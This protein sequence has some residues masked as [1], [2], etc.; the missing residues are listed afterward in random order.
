MKKYLLFAAVALIATSVSAQSLGEKRNALPAKSSV[1]RPVQKVKKMDADIAAKPQTKGLARLSNGLDKKFPMSSL[2]NIKVYESPAMKKM[3]KVGEIQTYYNASGTSRQL[4][5]TEWT[6]LSIEDEGVRFFADVIPNLWGTSGINY[7]LTEANVSGSTV[8]IPAQ[9]VLQGTQ[10]DGTPLYIHIFSGISANGS[11]VMTLGDDGSLTLQNGETIYYGAFSTETFDPTLNTYLG[12]YDYVTNI[13]YLFPGQIAAP[14]AEIEPAGVFLHLGSSR[15][16]YHY[17]NNLAIIPSNAAVP[18][19]NLTSGKVTKYDWSVNKFGYNDAADAMEVESVITGSEKDFSF[20]TETAGVYGPVSLTAWNEDTNSSY[21]W[22][23]YH[24]DDAN[25]AFYAYA[26]GLS[27]NYAFQDG[28]SPI[29]TTANPDNSM[30]YYATYFGTPDLM[31]KSIQSLVMY[32]GKPTAPL[33]T[34]GVNLYVR[35]FTAQPGFSLTCQIVQVSRDASNGRMS[36]GNV[37]AESV[38]SANDVVDGGNGIFEMRFT[39]FYVYDEDDMTVGIDHLFLDEEFAIVISGWDNGTFSCSPFGEYETS[40]NGHPYT[41]FIQTD[42]PDGLYSWTGLNGKMFVGFINGGYGYLNTSDPTTINVP[43]EGGNASITVHPM[44]YSDGEN[45]AKIT[46][47]FSD[48]EIPSWLTFSFANENY[49]TDYVFDLVVTASALPEGETGRSATIRFWQEGAYLDVT[50][51][52]GDATNGI[53]TVSVSKMAKTPETFNLAGQKVGK[54][55]KGIIIRDGKK[56][57][58]K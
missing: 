54:N 22:G 47:L 48:N 50:V 11:I 20:N 39:D 34:E 28:T 35:G 4:G 6:M 1:V 12:A 55:A 52:Q 53:A 24:E 3:A 29:L 49:D 32:Q 2:K 9:V 33:Y 17:T 13:Q 46:R 25:T 16:N 19:T 56:Y 14:K 8:T 18:F 51:N 37:I 40:E 36:F 30:A 31:T 27:S 42:D 10:A 58:G 5:S 41:Y 57:I 26:G 38:I 21:T 15:T 45:G 23:L 44:L 43:A 7:V